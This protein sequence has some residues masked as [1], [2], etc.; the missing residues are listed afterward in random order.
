M[1]KFYKLDENKSP[2]ECSLD[3]FHSTFLRDPD[4]RR[5]AKTHCGDAAISTVFLALDH[6]F[7]EDGPPILF[8][9]MVFGGELDQEQERY[10]TWAEAEQGHE[11]WIQKVKAAEQISS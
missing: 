3:D 6:S 5:V 2:V 11:R 8:E 7:G 4:A 1:N 10:A 9:T